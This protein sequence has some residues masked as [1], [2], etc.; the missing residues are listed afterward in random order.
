M[1]HAAPASREVTGRR[2]RPDVF[3]ARTHAAAKVALPVVLGL[4]YGYWAAA[5]R[6]DSGPITGWNLLFGF[7]TALVF[8]VLFA[9]LWKVAPRLKRELHALVWFVFTGCAVGFLVSQSDESVLESAGLG[10]VV[11]AGV[12]VTLFYRYY[13]HEDAAGHRVD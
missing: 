10:V 3:S 13:T 7:L 2:R 9:A 1:A 8:A 4:V 12:L 11:G 5:N 6:R